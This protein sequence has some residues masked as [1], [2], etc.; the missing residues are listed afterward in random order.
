[1][2][3]EPDPCCTPSVDD[4]QSIQDV[5]AVITAMTDGEQ[6]FLSETMKAALWD[7]GIGQVILC[8]E[9]E[10]TWVETTL[11][12]LMADPRL[13]ILRLPLALPGA[14]RNQAIQY[15][16]MPWVA[17]CDGDDVWCKGKTRTQRQYVDSMGCDL[18]GA[19]HYL[20]DEQG[21]IRVFGRAQ[22]LPMTS[23][24]MVRTELMRQHPFNES[25]AQGEDGE[26]WVRTRMT[27]TKVR[28]PKMLLRYRV[29]ALSLS[30]N[31]Q[32]KRRK[33]QL[34]ALSSIPILGSL[35][36]LGTIGL[37][38]SSRQKK[39]EWLIGWTEQ[40]SAYQSTYQTDRVAQSSAQ[41]S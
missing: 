3:H 1:M 28:C 24:W 25:L 2:L 38:L 8:V 10:N 41:K 9:A 40:Y 6:P 39:Y 19:D 20:T 15:V 37:W 31:T 30:S 21:R 32:S 4:S 18:V 36:S 26:W 23:S 17:Y 13:E 29:R 33:A 14:V 7:P 27:V 35:V 34:V 22:Y 12:P 11:G 16:R 5:A